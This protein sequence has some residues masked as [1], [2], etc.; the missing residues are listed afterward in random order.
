LAINQLQQSYNQTSGLYGQNLWWNSANV[1]TMLADFQEHFPSY[2]EQITNTVFPH[3]LAIA[4]KATGN[5]NFLNAFY[6]DELWWA[7]AWIKVFDVTEDNKYLD[8]ASVI[9]E[10]SKESWGSSPCGGL[11]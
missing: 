1:I 7:L 4:P 9:F 11:W 10:N 8:A 2:V 3:T 5:T 6:D